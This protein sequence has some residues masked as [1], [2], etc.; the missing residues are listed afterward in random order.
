MAKAEY[1]R[2]RAPQTMRVKKC[3]LLKLM[4]ALVQCSGALLD[5]ILQ[6]FIERI[7]LRVLLPHF[8]EIHSNIKRK[9]QCHGKTQKNEC[10]E[11]VVV[12]PLPFSQ[13]LR[14]SGLQ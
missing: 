7:N 3:I 13:L 14:L 5:G 2:N 10:C 8:S 12:T 11:H 1:P 4:I 9:N 6:I